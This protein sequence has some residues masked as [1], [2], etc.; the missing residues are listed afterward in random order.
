MKTKQLILK[1]LLEIIS[2]WSNIPVAQHLVTIM[3]PQTGNYKWD[4]DKLLKAIEKYRD[5]MENMSN[6]D[7]NEENDA[8]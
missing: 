6:E 1:E 8:Y 5:E 2:L 3:R 7:E 4:D